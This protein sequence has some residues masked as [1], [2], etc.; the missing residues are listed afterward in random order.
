M[1]P[2]YIPSNVRSRDFQLLKCG[3]AGLTLDHVQMQKRPGDL[4]GPLRA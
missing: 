1:T 4:A 3:G 2:R